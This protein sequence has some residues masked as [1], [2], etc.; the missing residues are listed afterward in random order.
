MVNPTDEEYLQTFL[1]LE[2]DGVPPIRARIAERLGITPAA[3]SEGVHRLV[4][5]GYLEERDRV[6]GLTASGKSVGTAV[7]RRHRLAECLLVD[8]LGLAWEKAHR[9]ASRWEHALSDDV[10]QRIVTL[11]DDPATCPHG[12]VIPGSRRAR[13]GVPTQPLAVTRAGPVRVVRISEQA[14]VDDAVLAFLVGAG[15][16]PGAAAEILPGA[17]GVAGSDGAGVA[18]RTPRGDHLVPRTVADLLWVAP[19]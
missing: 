18:V 9:E 13:A 6:L 2:E 12:N 7:I 19:V 5:R 3:V 10:E 14:Q 8:V 15:L 4:T 1:E 16:I 17:A 11:L